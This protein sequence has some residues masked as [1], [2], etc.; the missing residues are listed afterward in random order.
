MAALFVHHAGGTQVDIAFGG[1]RLEAQ[2]DLGEVGLLQQEF[3]LLKLV[4]AHA[5]GTAVVVDDAVHRF[6]FRIGFHGHIIA[7]HIE[8]HFVA[9]PAFVRARLS[10]KLL[11]LLLGFRFDLLQLG[12]GFAQVALFF[13]EDGVH[14]P[15]N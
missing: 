10:F 3:Q 9:H 7:L 15:P 8:R 5:A 12:V 6:H 2:L 4:V 1:A 11:Q 13:F 14:G